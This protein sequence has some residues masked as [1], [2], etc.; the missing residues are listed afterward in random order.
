MWSISSRCRPLKHFFLVR[1]SPPRDLHLHAPRTDHAHTDKQHQNKYPAVLPRQGQGSGQQRRSQDAPRTPPGDQTLSQLFATSSILSLLAR[2]RSRISRSLSL[3]CSCAT[4]ASPTGDWSSGQQNA[5]RFAR[6]RDMQV[7]RTRA[8]TLPPWVVRLHARS[9]HACTTLVGHVQIR[10]HAHSHTRHSLLSI[11]AARSLL[12]LS[13]S[14]PQR[15]PSQLG[16][17]W[18][19]DASPHIS[20]I[21]RTPPRALHASINHTSSMSTPRRWHPPISS[22]AVVI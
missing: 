16:A 14:P 18:R 6:A 2:P 20:L 9:A 1:T 11:W 7:A 3:S 5:T 13:H 10:L 15:R 8:R 22:S 19:L 4:K 12:L 21:W 17:A